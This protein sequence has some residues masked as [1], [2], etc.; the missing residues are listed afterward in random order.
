MSALWRR[1]SGALEA[2]GGARTTQTYILGVGASGALLAGAGVALI[3]LVGLVSFDVWPES[4]GGTGPAEAQLNLGGTASQPAEE[5]ALSGAVG[6]LTPTASTPAAGTPAPGGADDG[7]GKRAPKPPNS[8]PAGTAPTAPPAPGP[9]GG[10]G[11]GSGAGSGS[12]GNP[13]GV[14]N[15]PGPTPGRNPN[16]RSA[17]G[18]PQTTP[19]AHSRAGG[20]QN[21]PSGAGRGNSSAGRGN[22]SA[23]RS[24][25][26][27]TSESTQSTPGN[28]GSDPSSGR[29]R[30]R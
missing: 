25:S 2:S 28:S 17:S 22:S 26:G 27:V 29:G 16:A 4:P 11:N 8:P 14:V 18:K 3:S 12:S 6:I 9:G 10:D 21:G 24:G 7:G 13:G 30:G 20:R 19:P 5:A 23:G 15:P 1:H